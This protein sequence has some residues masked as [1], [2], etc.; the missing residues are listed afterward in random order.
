MQAS[1]IPEKVTMEKSGANKSAID[2]I[3]EAKDIA[4]EVNQCWRRSRIDPHEADLPTD[5]CPGP[6]TRSPHYLW[7]FR[8]TAG[9][10]K[11]RHLDQSAVGGNSVNHSSKS[12]I[13]I[14]LSG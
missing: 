4:V 7:T 13:A 3:I 2:Q 5:H 14:Y 8:V 11:N 10:T 6:T 1:G 12:M 9:S